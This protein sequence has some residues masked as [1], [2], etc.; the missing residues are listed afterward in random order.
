MIDPIQI[1]DGIFDRAEI[2]GLLPQEG[3]LLLFLR[4]GKVVTIHDMLSREEIEEICK[5]L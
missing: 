4:G 5:K 3:T 2:V 1:G